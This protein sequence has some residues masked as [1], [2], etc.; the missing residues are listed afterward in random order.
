MRNPY[1]VICA[2]LSLCASAHGATVWTG[3]NFRVD[4]SAATPVGVGLYGVTLTAVGLNGA[5]PNAFDGFTGGGTGIT[6]VGNHLAQVTEFTP[7]GSQTPTLQLQVPGDSVYYPI[8]T[9]FLVEPPQIL[10]IS[11]PS[12]TINVADSTEA[13]NAGFG[14]SLNGSFT[15][16]GGAAAT[17][18]F[19]YLVVPDGTGIDLNF[20]LAA[21]SVAFETVQSSFAVPE[22]STLALFLVG[23]LVMVARGRWRRS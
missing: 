23:L 5:L 12:E 19:A 3:T 1:L 7:L 15:L 11:P 2:L 4:A 9:H 10:V 8:D 14:D 22:P 20:R 16:A 17:W 13:P 6:T 18:D 21:P